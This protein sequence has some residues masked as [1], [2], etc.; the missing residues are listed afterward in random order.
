M[1]ICLPISAASLVHNADKDSL[2]FVIDRL[3]TD[4][5]ATGR[6]SFETPFT[7]NRNNEWVYDVP[8]PFS[9]VLKQLDY[10]IGIWAPV[11]SFL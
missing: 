7:I 1:S 8:F 2:A 9:D 4:R 6:S 5:P 11:K 10:A 3:G